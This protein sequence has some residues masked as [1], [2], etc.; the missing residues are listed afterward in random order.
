[1]DKLDLAKHYKTYYTAKSKPEYI[2]L[3]EAIPYLSILGKGDPSGPGFASDI[4]AMYTTAYALKFKYKA[5]GKDYV[6]AKLEGLWWYDEAAFEGLSIKEAS[7]KVPRSEWNYRLLIRLPEYVD[8]QFL[9]QM[10]HGLAAEKANPKIIDVHYFTLTEGKCVQMLH[11]GPFNKE[12]E[13]LE[14]MKTFMD[15]EGLGR[16]GLHHEIYLSDHRKTAPEKL[17]TILREPVK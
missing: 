12:P 14:V 11:V 10:K 8:G 4:Q 6:V 1:M 17:R 2:Q 16:N 9:E 15:A 5:E 13:T 7:V 3:D